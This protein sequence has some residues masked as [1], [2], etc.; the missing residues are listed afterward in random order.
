MGFPENYSPS[1]FEHLLAPL[2]GLSDS[3]NR[4]S[5]KLGD[6][7]QGFEASLNS[8]NIGT[9][10]WCSKPFFQEPFMDQGV[11][12][13]TSTMTLGYYRF[14]SGWALAVDY[15]PFQDGESS[16]Q[17]L[18]EAKRWVKLEA[19]SDIPELTRVIRKAA[20]ELLGKIQ[21]SKRAL[22]SLPR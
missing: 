7:I 12:V 21:K 13:D 6:Q 14:E 10:A 8:L 5:D 9:E 17:K 2:R 20:E 4:E 3:I 15:R 1:E 22:D 19:C 16:I 11:E 18:T